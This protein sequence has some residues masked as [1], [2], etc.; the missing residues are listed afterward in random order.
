M[1]TTTNIAISS[2]IYIIIYYFVYKFISRLILLC[3]PLLI[4][5]AEYMN[6]QVPVY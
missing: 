3:Y 2:T 4:I 6:E 5:M 1:I